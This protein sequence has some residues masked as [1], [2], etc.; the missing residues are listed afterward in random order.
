MGT[1]IHSVSLSQKILSRQKGIFI[2]KTTEIYWVVSGVIEMDIF[3]E[4]GDRERIKLNKGELVVI[5]PFEYH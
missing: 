2:K 3:K 4:E 5:E 1:I